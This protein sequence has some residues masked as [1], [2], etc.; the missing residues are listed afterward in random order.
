MLHGES[1]GHIPPL[2]RCLFEIT[3]CRSS[4][5]YTTDKHTPHLVSGWSPRGHDFGCILRTILLTAIQCKWPRQAI[6][7]VSRMASDLT[8]S[9][10][11]KFLK[12]GLRDEVKEYLG[13]TNQTNSN[14]NKPPTQ[15]G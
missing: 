7:R 15:Q 14:M 9:A 2:S 13:N 3:N 11:N 5:S 6:S 1:Y 4:A 12:K 10:L 8:G